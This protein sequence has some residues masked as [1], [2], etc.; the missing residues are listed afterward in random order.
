VLSNAE[1]FAQLYEKITGEVSKI[2]IGKKDIKDGLILALFAGGNVLIEGLPGT[3]KTSLA[4]SFAHVIG[5]KFKRIQFTPDM[6]PL[7][8]PGFMCILRPRNPDS[9]KARFSRISYWL[10]SLT[11]LLPE[12][13]QPFSKPC[14]NGR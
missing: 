4:R 9:S 6:M 12:P 3:A 11:V 13:S 10:T 5:G 8:S 2:I 7:I 14:R 1:S